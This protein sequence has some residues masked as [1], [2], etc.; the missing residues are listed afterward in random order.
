MAALTGDDDLMG[1]QFHYSGALLLRK[2]H[3]S[4]VIKIC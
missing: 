3:I 1:H 4:D 2:A